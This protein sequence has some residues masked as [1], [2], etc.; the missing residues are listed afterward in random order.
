MTI[1]IAGYEVYPN[2]IT[3]PQ[4]LYGGGIRRSLNGTAWRK[5]VSTKYKF[6]ATWDFMDNE[7]AQ[8]IRIIL[9]QA[10]RGEVTIT[11]DDPVINSSF[12]IANSEIALE[13]LEGDGC[14]YKLELQF[15][16]V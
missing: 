16:E 11:C 9:L 6:N 3:T 15:E 2:K 14:F 8:W 10:I 13:R 4:I 5:I 12:I 1:T 7:E